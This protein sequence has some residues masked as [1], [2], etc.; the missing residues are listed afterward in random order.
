MEFNDTDEPEHKDTPFESKEEKNTPIARPSDLA[1]AL[2]EQGSKK[3]KAYTN[4]VIKT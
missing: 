1:A 3:R 4:K 2:M